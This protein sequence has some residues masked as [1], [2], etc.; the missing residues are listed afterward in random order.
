MSEEKRYCQCNKCSQTFITKSKQKSPRHSGC[1]G[2]AKEITQEQ[3]ESIKTTPEK[4]PE[5]A[6]EKQ[7]ILDVIEIK[8]DEI[9]DEVLLPTE[10]PTIQDVITNTQSTLLGSGVIL[11]EGVVFAITGKMPLNESE[12][13]NIRNRASQIAKKYPKSI[14]S[15]PYGDEIEFAE[16]ATTPIL[17]R[18]SYRPKKKKKQSDENAT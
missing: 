6:P 3:F 1:G 13:S 15:L 2:Y 7:N 5:K 8:L 11:T 18:F 10:A 9:K 14:A 17:S 12:K 16:A 4:E